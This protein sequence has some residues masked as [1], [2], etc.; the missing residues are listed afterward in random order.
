[1]VLATAVAAQADYLVTGDGPFRRVEAYD[2]EVLGENWS[3]PVP[4]GMR[5]RVPM[6]EQDRWT[7]ASVSNPQRSFFSVDAVNRE[8]FE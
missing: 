3:D 4:G 2:G 1:V 7:G 5:V 8:S 6:Q